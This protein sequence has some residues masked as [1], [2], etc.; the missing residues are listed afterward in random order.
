MDKGVFCD[1]RDY[2]E[3]LECTVSQVI[4]KMHVRTI[5]DIA[6]TVVYTIG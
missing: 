5:E 2:G 4:Q 3:L 1:V 6:K